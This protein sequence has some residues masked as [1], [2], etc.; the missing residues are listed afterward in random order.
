MKLKKKT[1]RNLFSIFLSLGSL[2]AI[3]SGF[4]ILG[5]GMLIGGATLL[6]KSISEE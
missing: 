3:F 2:F 5:I 4:F 1:E 6:T